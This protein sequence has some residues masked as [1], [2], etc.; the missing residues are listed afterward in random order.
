MVALLQTE[1]GGFQVSLCKMAPSDLIHHWH[2]E[3]EQ[4]QHNDK[5]QLEKESAHNLLE[6]RMLTV[7]KEVCQGWEARLIDNKPLEQ[8]AKACLTT[9]EQLLMDNR[10]L[11]TQVCL[12]LHDTTGWGFP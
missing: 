9:I 10:Y 7:Q 6:K 3:E 11:T 5:M 2:E 4:M 1:H 12:I 8:R